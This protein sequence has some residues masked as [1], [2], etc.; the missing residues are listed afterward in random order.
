VGLRIETVEPNQGRGF[1]DVDPI[2]EERI[3]HCLM[4][5]V[6]ASDFS[7]YVARELFYAWHRL[8]LGVMA[9]KPR[10]FR[11]FPKAKAAASLKRTVVEYDDPANGSMSTLTDR[12]RE[13]VLDLLEQASSWSQDVAS[14]FRKRPPAELRVT[15]VDPR[16]ELNGKR[17]KEP[18]QPSDLVALCK[19]K[20]VVLLAP[21]G[22]GKTLFLDRFFEHISEDYSQTPSHVR[23]LRPLVLYFSSKDIEHSGFSGK[24]IWTTI[25]NRVNAV[26]AESGSKRYPLFDVFANAGLVYLLFDGLDEFGVQHRDELEPLACALAEQRPAGVSVVVTCRRSFWR[27]VVFPDSNEGKKRYSEISFLDFDQNDARRVLGHAAPWTRLPPSLYAEGKLAPWALNPQILILLRDLC[28]SSRGPSASFSTRFQVYQAW[29]DSRCKADA[30]LW[31]TPAENVKKFY[32]AL[33][34]EVLHN[35]VQTISPDRFYK[36]AEKELTRGPIGDRTVWAARFAR[37]EVILPPQ[38]NEGASF[39]HARLHEYFAVLDLVEEIQRV[40][41]GPKTLDWN[42]SRLDQ[43]ELDFIQTAAYGYF[44]DVLGQGFTLK[45][46]KFIQRP[47]FSSLPSNVQRNLIEY[48]GM[49]TGDANVQG[50]DYESLVKHLMSIVEGRGR[51]EYKVRFNAARALERIH[52]RAPR[53]YVE[54][55]S[56]WGH[57]EHDVLRRVDNREIRPWLMKGTGQLFAIPGHHHRFGYCDV[58]GPDDNLKGNISKRICDYLEKS[59]ARVRRGD[60]GLAGSG[61][62]WAAWLNPKSSATERNRDAAEEAAVRIS[63]SNAWVRWIHPTHLPAARKMAKLAKEKAELPT[64]E[65]LGIWTGIIPGFPKRGSKSSGASQAPRRR[66]PL[67]RPRTKP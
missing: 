18:L 40:V 34:F 15:P 52:L 38:A 44:R 25:R 64:L 17:S 32:C 42:S 58:P 6:E 54:Y 23:E 60:A 41:D 33:A 5:L 66:P 55:V 67:A 12:L 7:W 14:S 27:D 35:R 9:I 22:C 43:V 49:T 63:L 28:G 39:V 4:M 45:L 56:D 20:P 62:E 13:T 19:A 31:E 50:A 61:L 57:P 2:V 30:L 3:D 53:P 37:S 59:L 36:I 16:Y 29:S 46:A 10:V 8:P 1:R 11:G 47:R 65:N 48:V 26:C 21:E 24:D 51:F